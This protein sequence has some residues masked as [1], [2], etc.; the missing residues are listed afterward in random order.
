MIQSP[1]PNNWLRDSLSLSLGLEC[2]MS[3][4]IIVWSQG[5]KVARWRFHGDSEFSC[6][7][8]LGACL[9]AHKLLAVIQHSCNYFCISDA[10]HYIYKLESFVVNIYFP[11]SEWVLRSFLNCFHDGFIPTHKANLCQW[12]TILIT[13]EW[14][15]EFQLLHHALVENMV[16]KIRS[17][18]PIAVFLTT[19]LCSH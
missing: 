7:V 16:K 19:M 2:K 9:N 18:F 6:S 11:W 15:E 12:N 17:R 14:V 8:V 10:E 1:S 4:L 3:L 13:M 5:R